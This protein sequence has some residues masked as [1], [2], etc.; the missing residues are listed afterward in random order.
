MKDKK[1]K[2]RILAKLVRYCNI[3]WCV[4]VFMCRFEQVVVLLGMITTLA[5]QNQRTKI[6]LKQ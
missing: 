5:L 3:L 6:I 4:T 1:Q 2:K